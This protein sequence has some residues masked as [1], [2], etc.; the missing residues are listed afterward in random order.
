MAVIETR[1]GKD[2]KVS[3]YRVKVRLR[4]YAPESASFSTKSAAKAWAKK[5]EGD[6][7]TGRHFGASKRHTFNDLADEY[8]PRAKDPERLEYWRGVFGKITLDQITSNK[9]AKARDKLLSEDTNRIDPVTKKPAK[10]S[11]A[12]V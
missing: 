3:S 1:V 9:I 2:G 7:I 6:M 5:I 12:T 10:R 4:G 11:G 8:K